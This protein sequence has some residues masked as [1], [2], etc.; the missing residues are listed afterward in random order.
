MRFRQITQSGLALKEGLISEVTQLSF[1]LFG[2]FDFS[3]LT[4][5][6]IL[7]CVPRKEFSKF[8]MYMIEV[9][10]RGTD[11]ESVKTGKPINSV[12]AVFDMEG[13]T[14]RQIAHKQSNKAKTWF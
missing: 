7:Q 13:L 8:A 1:L 11:E 10:D 9:I 3:A 4:S 12:T 14:M 6:G 5:L 2:T